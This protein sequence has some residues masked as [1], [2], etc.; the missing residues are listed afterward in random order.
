M[1]FLKKILIKKIIGVVYTTLTY[2]EIMCNLFR[3]RKQIDSDK[4]FQEAVMKNEKIMEKLKSSTSL[5]ITYA[6]LGVISMVAGVLLR[7]SKG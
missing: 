3:Y 5:T 6:G 4:D 2:R 7:Y 1:I